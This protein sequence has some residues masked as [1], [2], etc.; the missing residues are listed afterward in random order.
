MDK[1]SAKSRSEWEPI[2]SRIIRARVYSKFVKTT[3]LQCYA[4]TEQAE[5]E[6]KEDFYRC[7]QQQIDKTPRH[8]ILLVMG[9]FNAKVGSENH[10]YEK[11]MGQQGTGEQNDHGE[12]FANLCLEN[13]LVIGGTIFQLTQGN[14]YTDMD[15]TRW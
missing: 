7:L 8:N 11:C 13:G 2:N 4:P 3:V 9:D 12:R 1:T 5:E 6:D 14:P 15:L 10:G